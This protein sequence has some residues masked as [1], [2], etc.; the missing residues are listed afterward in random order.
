[1]DI[2]LFLDLFYLYTVSSDMHIYLCPF[3]S[4]NLCLC[5]H[6]HEAQLELRGCNIWHFL[7]L[8]GSTKGH[9][10]C[11]VWTPPQTAQVHK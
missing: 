4:Q 1:M 6:P 10:T 11:A 7:K 8:S 2:S 5:L 9:S 3:L